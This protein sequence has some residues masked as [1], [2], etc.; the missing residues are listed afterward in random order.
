MD[1]GLDILPRHQLQAEIVAFDRGGRFEPGEHRLTKMAPSRQ[2]NKKTGPRKGKG[3]LRGGYHRVS[4][5]RSIA[6][7]A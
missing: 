1:T 6:L 2:F 3:K 4:N 7:V 5:I